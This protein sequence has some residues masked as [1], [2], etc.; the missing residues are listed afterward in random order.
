MK[1]LLLLVLV[2]I[3]VLSM[4]T[5]CQLIEQLLGGNGDPNGD[6][7]GDLN[8]DPNGD[9]NGNGDEP[10]VPETVLA[11][12]VDGDVVLIN[13]EDETAQVTSSGD[14]SWVGWSPDGSKL[15]IYREAGQ[16]LT[17]NADGSDLSLLTAGVA[18]NENHAQP[19]YL[20]HPDS[21]HVGCVLEGTS[22]VHIFNLSDGTSQVI[23]FGHSPVEGPW[24]SQS[25]YMAVLV[26]R[27]VDDPASL[28]DEW[29]EEEYDYEDFYIRR[30][31]VVLNPQGTEIF[32]HQSVWSMAW[33][34]DNMLYTTYSVAF[35]M[36]FPYV[37][38]TYAL[39]AGSTAPQEID[40]SSGIMG[41]MGD[42]LM[43]YATAW[44]S[45]GIKVY[46]FANNSLA[47][48]VYTQDYFITYSEFEYPF[49]FAPAHHGNQLA[50]L[51][52]TLESEEEAWPQF[53]YWDL[54]VYDWDTG[55]S[56]TVWPEVFILD[57]H[58]GP[59]Q[60]TISFFWSWDGEHIYVFQ[61][62]GDNQQLWE[63]AADGSGSTRL[64]LPDCDYV[65]S[66]PLN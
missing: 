27:E 37:D 31:L 4:A 3:L 47:G 13:D 39:P 49:I 51:A 59:L 21:N 64:V 66:R 10:D 17:M 60:Y 50:I 48:P 63:V 36:Q 18:F 20:W 56:W 25:G 34:G 52:L 33:A 62:D 65:A 15:L 54:D 26:T 53:G 22:E 9:P 7:N 11:A 55:S 29:W 58:P 35:M 5:G 40:G 23:D 28:R 43:A 30:H 19:G 6:T 42:S 32:E 24:W 45:K 2:G 8:G 61:E 57:E 1:R 38:G 46:N 44:Q 14:V 41:A 16:L 12:I